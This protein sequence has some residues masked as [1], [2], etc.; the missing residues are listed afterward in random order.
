MEIGFRPVT[1]A[2]FPLLGRWL[3]EP[4]VARWWCHETSP[5]AVLRDFGPT[6]RGEE[7]AEDFLVL[8]AGRPVGL[9]QRNRHADYPE[10][11]EEL[12]R[13]VEVPEGAFGVDYLIG[14]P[15]EI[16]HGLGPAVIAAMVARIWADHPDATCVIVP[17]AAAN[18]RSWRA[19]EKAGLGF[20]AEA[21]LEP[22][23]PVDDRRHVVHRIDRPDAPG[24]ARPGRP[25]RPRPGTA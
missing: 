15:D 1:E 10:D 23:N 25:C 12:A 14:E 4:H 19:L 18:R 2:D 21:D 11:R 3:S 6:A 22:D 24:S 5:E 20:V 9:I 13:S 16:G 8:L 7:P 17:V